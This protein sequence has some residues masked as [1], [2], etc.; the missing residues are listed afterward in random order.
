MVGCSLLASALV[1]VP[2]IG[3]RLLHR[4]H[5]SGYGAPGINLAQAAL[6]VRNDRPDVVSVD[7]FDT[8]IVR[9]L[10]GDEPIEHAI[11][12]SVNQP[13]RAGATVAARAD[14]V[15][16]AAGFERNLCRPVPG[17]AEALAEI[18]ATGAEIVFL[19]DT[20]RSSEL[21]IEIL[22]SHGI[23]ASGDRLIASCEAGATK[24]DGDLFTK[25][26]PRSGDKVVW[27]LG[28]NLWADVTMAKKAGL[29][30][31]YIP[32]AN[33]NRYETSMAADPS[34]YG[35]ALSG[36]ARSARLAIEAESRAGILDD[37][38]A[39]I[40]TVGADI[41]GQSMTA[42]VLWVAEQCRELDIA[43]LGFLA[44]DGELPLRV[45]RSIPADHWEGRTL[46]YL[47]SSRLT[48]SL[49]AAS[50]LGVEQWLAEG[51]AEH[52]AFLHTKRHQI[53]FDALLARLGLNTVDLSDGSTH[54]GLAGLDPTAPLPEHAVE[55]WEA[56]LADQ[57]IR[58]RIQQRAD[59]RFNLIVDYLRAGD[60]PDGRFGLVDVGWRGRLAWHVSAVFSEVVG[61]E[62]VHLHFGGDKVISEVDAK[63]HIRRFAFDGVSKPVPIESPVSCIETLTASGKARVIDYRRNASGAV[64]LVFD[65]RPTDELDGARQDLWV[66]ATRMAELVPTRRDLDNWGL[67]D[68]PLA[69][70]AKAVLDHWWNR[71]TKAEVEAFSG[72]TF[73]HDEAG[74]TFRP[75]VAPYALSEFR[76]SEVDAARQWQQ[77]SAVVSSA[78]LSLLARLVWRI[79]RLRERS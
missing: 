7:V 72:M 74:T 11:A 42:F 21:L 9:D 26:W 24:S 46:R 37:R 48:W 27:H 18:R 73:E 53:P 70:E 47:Y 35:P 3:P 71:P 65:S 51:V 58:E 29:H 38:S 19:S 40:Q 16:V 36:A 54:Q 17:A 62:P 32:D 6:Q 57:S 75:L 43:H 76:R 14:S 50:T 25:T 30:A 2:W 23:F 63:L 77:G 28:N 10:A 68:R 33:L 69:E 66:G 12:Q 4:L 15:A 44:R 8:C 5:I 1:R 56:L 59:D 61:T 45:A 31:I 13:A 64:E 67:V 39:A 60:L 34:G 78:P 52:D 49:A 79:R 41:A 22:T 20:D 55:R